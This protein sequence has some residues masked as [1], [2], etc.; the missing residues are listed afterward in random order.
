MAKIEELEKI[1][2]ESDKLKMNL[3][4][5]TI[6][7]ISTALGIVAGLAWNE[8]IKALIEFLFPLGSNTLIA[9]FVYAFAITAFVVFL[10][11]YFLKQEN[12]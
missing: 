5:K 12:K 6:G 10:T 1:K 3:R 9:K 7:Y 2:Q 4:T 8:A 11:S